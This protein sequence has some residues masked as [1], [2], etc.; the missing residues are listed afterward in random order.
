MQDL[1][2]GVEKELGSPVATFQLF[3]VRL[4]GHGIARK[5]KEFERDLEAF[6]ESKPFLRAATQRYL[7]KKHSQR[8]MPRMSHWKKLIRFSRNGNRRNHRACPTRRGA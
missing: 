3:R 1:L 2:D 8:W 5:R 6:L 4:N 7:R